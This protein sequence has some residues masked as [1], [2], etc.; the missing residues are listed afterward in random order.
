MKNE[1]NFS[2]A[3]IKALQAI[4]ADCDDIDGEGFTTPED[5]FMAVVHQ[6]DSGEQAGECIDGLRAKGVVTIDIYDNTLW[7]DRDVFAAFS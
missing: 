1:V 2:I 5:A 4:C 6:F 3:E 7:V